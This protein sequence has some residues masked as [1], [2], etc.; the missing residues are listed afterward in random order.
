MKQSIRQVLVLLLIAAVMVTACGAQ[1]TETPP[2]GETPS[3]GTLHGEA[4]V[5]TIDILILESFPIQVNVIARGYLPDGCTEIDEIHQERADE[6][7]QITIT[8][9]RPA[10]AMCTEAIVPFEESISLDVYGLPAGSYSVDA[11]GVTGAFE[12][13]MDNILP[14]EPTPA[15]ELQGGVLATFDVAGEQF[16]VWVTNPQTIQQILDLAAGNSLANIPNGRIVRGPGEADHNLPWSWHLDA[17]EIEMAEMTIEVCDG[18]PSYVEEHVDEFADTVGRYCP[19][20]ARLVS[21]D[22]LLEEQSPPPVLVVDEHPIVEAEVDGPGHVEYNDRLGEEI[23][24]RIEG[25][26]VQA[27]EQRLAQANAALAPFG[28]RLESRFDAEWNQ[29]LYDLFREGKEK[30]K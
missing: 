5:E 29:T 1:P 12:L 25:L 23:L 8:T 10:D 6:A 16:R 22:V 18:T 4:V 19:W 30:P 7:F 26:R 24:A 28:Y 27:A 13:S 9:V 17:E 20:S 11:N 14:A 3:G 21:V 2:A 15:G